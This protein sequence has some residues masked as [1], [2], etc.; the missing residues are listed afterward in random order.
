MGFL[1]V[2]G[3]FQT[4]I[5]YLFLS[6]YRWAFGVL[7]WELV[8]LGKEESPVNRLLA[9]TNPCK[10]REKVM[11]KISFTIPSNYGIE[12]WEATFDQCSS[13]PKRHSATVCIVN[14]NISRCF[15]L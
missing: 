5:V 7:L 8:T 12:F 10:I 11:R 6:L 3:K 2:R 9:E 1:I 15:S 14:L 13:F 4:L